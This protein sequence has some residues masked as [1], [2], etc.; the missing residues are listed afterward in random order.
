MSGNDNVTMEDV[1]LPKDVEQQ[2]PKTAK[3]ISTEKPLS[4]QPFTQKLPL[5]QTDPNAQLSPVWNPKVVRDG[6]TREPEVEDVNAGS[7][8]VIDQQR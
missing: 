3:E 8:E 5:G 4:R 1:D 2:V 6:H 7:L